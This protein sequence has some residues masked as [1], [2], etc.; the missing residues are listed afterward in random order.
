M[1]ETN[2]KVQVLKRDSFCVLAQSIVIQHD[3]YK[4]MIAVV[5]SPAHEPKQTQ[6]LACSLH[7]MGRSSV[8]LV[9][10]SKSGLNVDLKSSTL[11]NLVAICEFECTLH[12]NAYLL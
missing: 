1:L 11:A 4:P 8:S 7:H 2:S 9:L 10:R 5:H 3:I 6:G 12:M